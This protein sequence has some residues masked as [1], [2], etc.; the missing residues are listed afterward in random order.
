MQPLTKAGIVLGLGLGGFVDGIVLHQ[1]L[2]WHHLICTTDTCQ[3][4]T[5]EA[6]K[7]Q[8]AQDGFFHLATWCLTAL[9][10]ALLFRAA[11]ADPQATGSSLLGAMLCGWGLF[12]LVEG[13]VDHHILGIHHVR[14]GHAHE[15]AYDLAFLAS[16]A[17]LLVA[18][19]WLVRRKP[20][21]RANARA[22][23]L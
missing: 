1:I 22:G 2:G 19:I 13:I 18:G 6:L 14:P 4:D 3:V 15:F 23:S 8:N 17:L 20:H 5:V 16:G 11:R 21:V 9:G 7:L 10:V 12:N